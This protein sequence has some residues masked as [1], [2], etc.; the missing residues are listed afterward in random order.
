[1]HL[2]YFSLMISDVLVGEDTSTSHKA[3]KTGI[4]HTPPAV[5]PLKKKPLKM[6]GKK[7]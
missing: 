6:Q 2:F 5:T 3:V 7:V 4:L 1:M